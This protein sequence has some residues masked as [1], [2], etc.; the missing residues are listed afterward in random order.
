[1]FQA[2]ADWLL[3]AT[4]FSIKTWFFNELGL[5]YFVKYEQGEPCLERHC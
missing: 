2:V 4:I 1:M 5:T 3:T